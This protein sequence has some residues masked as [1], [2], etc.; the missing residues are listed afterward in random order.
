MLIKMQLTEF[1][2]I[3]WEFMINSKIILK[4]MEGPGITVKGPSSMYLRIF[5]HPHSTMQF[6]L[7]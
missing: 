1:L 4:S 5:S 6:S 2:Q 3:F 7:P